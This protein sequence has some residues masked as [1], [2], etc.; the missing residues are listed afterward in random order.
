VPLVVVGGGGALPRAA[1]GGVV[2]VA[3]A[4]GGVVDEEPVVHRFATGTLQSF[5]EHEKLLTYA[6]G[7]AAY[8]AAVLVAAYAYAGTTVALA[9]WA[10]EHQV[11]P[12]MQA[13]Q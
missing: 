9:I 6:V 12:A 7:F 8:I 3:T 5:V 2:V 10:A 13:M 4:G 11:L 1:G